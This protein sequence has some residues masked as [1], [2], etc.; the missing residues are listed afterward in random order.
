MTDEEE[1]F[2]WLDGELDAEASA[3]VAAR[4][5]ADPALEALAAEHRELG[6]QLR[7]AFAPTLAPMPAELLAS[8]PGAERVAAN[9]NRRWASGLAIAAS[10]A[11]AFLFGTQIGGGGEGAGP[12]LVGQVDGMVVAQ[13]PLAAALDTRLAADPAG[14][15]RIGLTFADGAD[16]LCRSFAAPGAQGV[17]CRQRG[18]WA[19]EGLFAGP[20]EVGD[21]RMASGGDPRVAELVDALIVGEPYDAA[22]E[23]AALG[24]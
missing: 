17:A 7:G 6:D 8:R 19:I 24:R 5:A 23:A 11:V 13:G 4:V 14:E 18:D 3:R 21:Y 1:F 16:R 2:A 20:G 12:G 10:L 9:D 15:V 22:A